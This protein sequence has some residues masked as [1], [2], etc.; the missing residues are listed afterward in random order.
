[1]FKGNNKATLSADGKTSY[2]LHSTAIVTD[3]AE[4]I[5][6]NSGG[7]MTPTTKNAMNEVGLMLG[8]HVRQ[9]NKEWMVQYKGRSIPFINGM[10]LR[11][12]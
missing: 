6:L 10:I 11:K 12:D 3:T 2:V 7:W 5:I 1:M 8:F 9:L 4:G